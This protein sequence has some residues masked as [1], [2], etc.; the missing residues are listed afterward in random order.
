MT[1]SSLMVA[2]GGIEEETIKI[3]LEIYIEDRIYKTVGWFWIWCK[4]NG[5]VKDNS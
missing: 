5:G 1:T 3:Y 2:V 4:G